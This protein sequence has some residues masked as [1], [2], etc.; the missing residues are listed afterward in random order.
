MNILLVAVL[1]ILAYL[2]TGVAVA[3]TIERRTNHELQEEGGS[4]MVGFAVVLWPFALLF[5]LLYFLG[6]FTG[7]LARDKRLPERLP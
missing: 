1:V 7:G 5:V 4:L 3:G 2:L 6:R